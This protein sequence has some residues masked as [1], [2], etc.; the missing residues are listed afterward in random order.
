MTDPL[1][2]TVA[3]MP[4]KERDFLQDAMTELWKPRRVMVVCMRDPDSLVIHQT[5]SPRDTFASAA[6]QSLI[7]QEKNFVADDK[8]RVLA[9]RDLIS[10]WAYQYAD[11][12]L[13]ASNT[14]SITHDG[15]TA[16]IEW[17]K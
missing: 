6:M 1:L 2:I 9:R 17:D 16:K 8:T 5:S 15:M 7:L 13:K 10:G 11:A 4:D 3:P 12:M 14:D